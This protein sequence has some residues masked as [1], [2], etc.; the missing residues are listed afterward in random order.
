MGPLTFKRKKEGTRHLTQ[1][2][3][4]VLD[5]E[6]TENHIVHARAKS[7]SVEQK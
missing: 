6:S 5:L 4:K 1:F 7:L 3:I 2:I